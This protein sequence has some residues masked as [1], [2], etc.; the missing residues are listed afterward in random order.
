[1]P[2][3][4]RIGGG[5]EPATFEIDEVAYSLSCNRPPEVDAG[6]PYEVPEGGSVVLNATGSDPEGNPLTY[7][8]D[9]D[10]DGVFETSGQS[11]SFSAAL[12]NGPS[13]VP[14]TVRASDGALDAIATGTVEVLNVAPTIESI[15]VSDEPLPIGDSV[16]ASAT[17]TDPAGPDDGPFTCTVDFGDGTP[18][19]PGTVVD[20]NCVAPPHHYAGAGVYT[21]GFTVTDADGGTSEVGVSPFLVIFDASGGHVT[22]GGAIVSPPGALVADPTAEGRAN[23]G[24]VARYRRGANVPSGNT[25]F[26]FHSGDLQFHSESYDWL[27][28]A[29][30]KA[31]FKGEGRVNGESGYRFMLSA[32]D[33]DLNTNDSFETDMFRI[34]IWDLATE[35]IVYDSNLGG[36]ETADPA[37]PIVSGQIRI[38]R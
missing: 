19:E 14:V 29:G 2:F 22:G 20:G 28:V 12:L 25:Q 31:I 36:D 7:E 34:K 16:E 10:D 5:I 6:G 37:T 9:L 30:S 38:H 23:F 33:A 4:F 3:V 17:F 18:G 13:I 15:A 32:I 24:F 26:V 27:V 11:V 1:V 8:W 21:I 35:A